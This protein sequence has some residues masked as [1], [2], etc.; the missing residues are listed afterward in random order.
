VLGRR[1]RRREG[2][3]E[4]VCVDVVEEEKDEMPSHLV[5]SHPLTSPLSPYQRET[6][7]RV[8]YACITTTTTRPYVAMTSPPL[9]PPP[10]Y[11][12]HLP[13]SPAAA[14]RLATA[15]PRCGA[16]GETA[17]PAGKTEYGYCVFV[18]RSSAASPRDS[19]SWLG[20]RN[21]FRRRG[22]GRRTFFFLCLGGSFWVRVGGW[23]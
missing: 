12:T 16:A 13:T 9:F 1:A 8:Y 2:S 18:K 3:I 10:S 19:T 20:G 22:L 21:L 4:G 7:Q 5:S 15:Q 17:A 11:A 23:Q 6:A 14:L